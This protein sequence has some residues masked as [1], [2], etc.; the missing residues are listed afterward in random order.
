[1]RGECGW[2]KGLGEDK[3]VG[4]ST[5]VGIGNGNGIGTGKYI[6][7]VLS[8]GAVIPK[9][10]VWSGSPTYREVNSPGTLRKAVDVL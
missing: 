1:M 4:D 5:V 10:G 2:D 6:Y 8:K 9:V 3:G 7:K